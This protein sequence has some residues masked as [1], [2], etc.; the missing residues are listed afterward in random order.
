MACSHKCL[1]TDSMESGTLTNDSVSDHLNSDVFG[2]SNGIRPPGSC[3][4]FWQV[5]RRSRILK[6]GMWGFSRLLWML[7]KTLRGQPF[8]LGPPC[9]PHAFVDPM[10]TLKSS[11]PARAA[12]SIGSSVRSHAFVRT[13]VHSHVR[14]SLLSAA[15]GVTGMCNR[16]VHIP[17]QYFEY[18]PNC[19][20]LVIIFLMGLILQLAYRLSR[21]H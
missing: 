14:L 19:Q 4:R 12:I 1:I 9:C 16:I 10:D 3:H 21:V 15:Q 11:D 2:A 20:L 6:E 18:S 17:V 8:P 7:L 13:S 5:L